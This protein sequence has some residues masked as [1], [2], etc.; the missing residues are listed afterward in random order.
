[1]NKL[2][3]RTNKL[4][5]MLQLNKRMDVRSVADS[6][7]IS[8]ATARRFFSQLE[9][10]G[11]VIRVH[12][13]VQLAPQ[14]GYDYS[15][16]VQASHRQKQKALIGTHAAEIVRDGDRLFLDSGTTVL[17]LAEAL[18]L[19]LR[20]GHLKSLVV[21]TNS[22]THVETV[23]RWCKVILI[24]GEIRVE[25]LDVCG[26][27]AEKTLAMFHLDKAFLGAD[28]VSLAGGCMTTDERTSTMNEIVVERAERCFVLAD[29]HK[30]G[31][32]SFIRYAP[33]SQIDTIFTDSGLDRETLSRYAEAGAHVEVVRARPEDTPRGKPA[34]RGEQL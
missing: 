12:G 27:V 21:L 23:A 18:A 5:E 33:F 19:R 29:S 3:L 16:R 24:G 11:K 17:K 34:P 10:E 14:L 1:M 30:F 28:A 22:I 20:T 2:E 13:G 7:C 15:F 9:E 4:L 6:L 26:S 32:T 8:E 31:K 25:R